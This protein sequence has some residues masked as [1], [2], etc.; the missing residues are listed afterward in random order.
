[1]PTRK[2]PAPKAATRPAH[3]G[4]KSAP[5]ASVRQEHRRDAAATRAGIMQ[6]ARRRFSRP[7]Y[8]HVGVR[9]IA[10]DA[11]VNAALVNRYFGS[12]EELF[13][14][15]AASAF[16]IED[17]SRGPMSEWG[18]RTAKFLM[19]ALPPEEDDGDFNPFQFLLGSVLSPVAAPIVARHLHANFIIPL[20]E[21]IGTEDAR[22]RAS[23]A[24]SY[25][26]GFAMTRVA[27]RLPDF[28]IADTDKVVDLLGDAIQR[29]LTGADAE[30]V[31][32]GSGI[33]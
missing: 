19:G 3:K 15:I 22:L 4:R 23:I 12:K 21:R 16:N 13:A 24:T 9:E 18:E 32:P 5:A 33:H 28:R 10:A 31:E 6:A 7:G 26:L 14:E 2:R 27:L 20:A 30:T 29:C 1:M 17:V 8:D 11:G 25:V